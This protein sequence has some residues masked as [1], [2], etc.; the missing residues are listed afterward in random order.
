MYNED[1]SDR[2]SYFQISGI[3][4]LP[5]VPWDNVIGDQKNLTAFVWGGYCTH[6]SVI[7]PTWHRPYVMLYEVCF[8]PF[9]HL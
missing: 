6:E 5:N 2:E 7:F 1:Q 4:G 8:T 9:L 3:H